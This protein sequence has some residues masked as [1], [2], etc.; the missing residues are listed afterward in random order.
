MWVSL[1]KTYKHKTSSYTKLTS[2][3]QVAIQNFVAVQKKIL[4]FI[5]LYT[6]SIKLPCIMYFKQVD[7]QHSL[8]F[9]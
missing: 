7:K 4:V 3:T 1:V 2:T 6:Y 5:S 8:L 9:L